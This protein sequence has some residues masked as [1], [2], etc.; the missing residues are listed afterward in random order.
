MDEAFRGVVDAHKVQRMK[1]DLANAW[2]HSLS[3]IN[4]FYPY[5]GDK[6]AL[7]TELLCIAV[8]SVCTV[9]IRC[10]HTDI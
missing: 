6:G 4:Q 7:K 5:K 2:L 9:P 1:E 3:L 8:Q 10:W